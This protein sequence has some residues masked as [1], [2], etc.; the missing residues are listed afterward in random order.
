MNIPDEASP[1]EARD[2]DEK[3][4]SL[5][6]QFVTCNSHKVSAGLRK[7][8]SPIEMVRICIVFLSLLISL[9]AVAQYSEVIRA[10]RPGQALT[11]NTVGQGI[12][13]L[14]TGFNYFGSNVTTKAT[15]FLSNTVIRYG[16]TEQ[17]EINAQFEYKGEQIDSAVK[18]PK[19]V[20]AAD[21]GIRYNIYA[22]KG[23]QPNIGFQFVTRLPVLGTDY[24]IQDPAPR[25]FIIAN[26]PLSDIINLNAI[27]GI[28]WNGN[29][30]VPRYNYVINLS[31]SPSARL[32][33]FAEVYGGREAGVLATFFD[34]GISWLLTND[35][36]LGL[37]GGLGHGGTLG[38]DKGANSYFVSAGV[39]WRTKRKSRQ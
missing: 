15:G 33:V 12:F 23:R 2:P 4:T 1:D 37:H 11:A 8:T 26:Q 38:S 32:G 19:G 39:S 7:L 21:I 27:W 9:S 24:K 13:Q 30:S 20:S 16:V 35:L 31:L 29:N 25:M 10:D 22:G 18:N 6:S 14:Q 28:T 34:G 5:T 3:R 17:F 36:Q